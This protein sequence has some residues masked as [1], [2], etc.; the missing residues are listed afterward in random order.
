MSIFRPSEV[1]R[2]ILVPLQLALPYA[3]PE[4]TL[5]E[6]VRDRVRPPPREDEI[7]SALEGLRRAGCIATV[8][9]TELDQEI[10]KYTIKEPG[11]ALLA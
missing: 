3:L 5:R 11:L 9:G 7:D 6:A 10:V 1:R 8:P 2:A 4:E